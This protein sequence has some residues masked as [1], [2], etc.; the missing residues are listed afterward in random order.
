MRA[1]AELTLQIGSSTASLM[2]KDFKPKRQK[3]GTKRNAGRNNGDIYRGGRTKSRRKKIKSYRAMS[4]AAMVA[5]L[6]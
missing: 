6:G 2:M 5:R 1:A 4:H 3:D